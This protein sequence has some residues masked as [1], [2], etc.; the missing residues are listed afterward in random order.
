MTISGN[1]H[2]LAM[3]IAEGFANITMATLRKYTQ[4]DLKT[5]NINLNMCIRELRQAQ[6]PL[7]DVMALKKR[8]MKIQRANQALSVIRNYCKKKRIVI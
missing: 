6:I 7:E 1:P 5:I 2:K 8:N 4:Q 3:D